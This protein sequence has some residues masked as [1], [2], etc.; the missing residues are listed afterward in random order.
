MTRCVT[1]TP[2]N[3]QKLQRLQTVVRWIV[4]CWLQFLG[5]Y[6]EGDLPKVINLVWECFAKLDPAAFIQHILT[7]HGDALPA[8]SAM[9]KLLLCV[10]VTSVGCERAFSLQNRIKTKLRNRLGED[11]VDMLMRSSMGPSIDIFEHKAAV[12][13]WR[14]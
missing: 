7:E 9:C 3:H 13:H 2:A 8:Y 10:S 4:A 11:R 6:L 12:R 14:K 1:G 5:Y